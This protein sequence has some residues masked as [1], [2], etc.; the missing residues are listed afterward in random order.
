MFHNTP[1]LTRL[2]LR[3]ER[4]MSTV[5]VLMLASVLAMIYITFGSAMADEASRTQL[6]GMMGNPAMVAMCGPVYGQ[7]NFTIGAMY[8][9]MMLLFT[10]IAVAVANIIFVVR[11]TRADEE[12]GRYEVVRSLPVGRLSNLHAAMIS[13]VLVN[14]VMGLVVALAL[15]LIGRGE[16]S[17]TLNGA[18]LWGT[19]LMA[20]GL[21]FASIAALFAQLSSSSRG[22]KGYSFTAL[23]VSYLL[24]GAGDA[25]GIEWLSRISPMGLILRAQ[26]FIENHWW[27]VPI[28]LLTAVGIAGI[29]YRLNLRRDIDQGLLPDKSGKPYGGKLL[30]HHIGL[31]L[32][33]LL[34]LLI[35]GIVTMS[36]TAASYGSIIGDIDG[37]IK[38]NA[39]Y[40]QLLLHVDG[41]TM[42]QLFAGMITMQ[43]SIFS[44]IF[45][46]LYINKAKGE[47]KEHRSELIL[48]APIKRASYL[49]GYA[50]ISFIASIVLQL[51]TAFSLY[52]VASQL[53][54]SPADLPLRGLIEANLA[55]LPA[56]WAFL[57]LALFLIGVAPKLT[58]LIWAAFGVSFFGA[59]FGNMQGLTW[60]GNLSPHGMLPQLPME[61]INWTTVIVMLAV[62]LSLT[63]LGF[64][65]YRRRDI[66]VV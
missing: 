46:L 59:M 61:T 20:I 26:P 29:A 11:H 64:I 12:K 63:T 60:L 51:V 2:A 15:F 18:L 22:A 62:A 27:P 52:V 36:L 53:L 43:M 58:G 10:A 35:I 42:P 28:L 16:S 7:D 65:G 25:G 34:P 23:A 38:S 57:G 31:A 39:F 37:F 45:L 3:R 8:T 14:I 30:T 32:K 44:L 5:W 13:A 47:E 1:T 54:N 17:I 4:T 50:V 49:N 56:Q 40:K 9:V 24:R 55:Y 41:F 19:I 66:G 6:A 33:L 48:S 21:V